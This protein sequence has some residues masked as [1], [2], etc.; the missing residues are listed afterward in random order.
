[1]VSADRTG[2][3]KS[4]IGQLSNDF[5]WFN[6]YYSGCDGVLVMI[7]PAEMLKSDAYPAQPFWVFKAISLEQLKGNVTRFF[8]SLSGSVLSE[9]TV[10]QRLKEF[11]LD[12]E[13]LMKNYLQRVEKRESK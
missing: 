2:I 8:N 6:E 3:S 4:E 9:E 5:G 11:N 7:H 10:L 13:N 12:T 1:M